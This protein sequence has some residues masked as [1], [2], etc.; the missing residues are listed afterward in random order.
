MDQSDTR[1]A[2][3]A[4]HMLALYYN[5]RTTMPGV[6][7]LVSRERETPGC[8]VASVVAAVEQYAAT[9]SEQPYAPGKVVC[10]QDETTLVGSVQK[11]KQY[12]VTSIL[13][14]IHSRW[15]V[16]VAPEGGPL[17]PGTFS[18]SSF[19]PVK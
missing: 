13:P 14:D 5:I 15:G 17:I 7:K 11:G 18:S 8:T 10:T 19:K 3:L 12:T 1:L 6:P 2:A 9:L 16:R 4:E